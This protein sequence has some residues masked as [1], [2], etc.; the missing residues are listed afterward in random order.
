MSNIHWFSKEEICCFS[1]FFVMDLTSVI[2]GR[3]SSLKTSLTKSWHFSWIIMFRTVEAVFEQSQITTEPSVW[4]SYLTAARFLLLFTFQTLF[5]QKPR[6]E[7]NHWGT[8]S[9][10]NKKVSI[11][12][13]LN[14]ATQMPLICHLSPV[15]TLKLICCFQKHWKDVCSINSD[16]ELSWGALMDETFITS[17]KGMNCIFQKHHSCSLMS[18][19]AALMALNQIKTVIL[20]YPL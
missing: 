17:E 3:T 8:K 15:I 9:N 19:K 6:A 2:V 7:N 5:K 16:V 20:T 13:E 12:K 10:S 11:S 14:M 4:F 18:H 1:L